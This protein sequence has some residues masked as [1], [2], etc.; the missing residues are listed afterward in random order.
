MHDVDDSWFDVL[1]RPAIMMENVNNALKK[2]PT[3]L[4]SVMIEKASIQ[5]ANSNILHFK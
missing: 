2:A 1:L 5:R 3:Y 4:H